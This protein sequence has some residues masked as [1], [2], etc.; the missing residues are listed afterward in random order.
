M[1]SIF[2]K[3]FI[4]NIP[5]YKRRVIRRIRNSLSKLH[6]SIDIWSSPTRTNLQAI[7]CHFL[8][9]KTRKVMKACLALAE[10]PEQY[11]AEEQAD[12]FL[13]VLKEYNIPHNHIGAF[14]S[15]N[16]GSNDKMIR[17]LQKTILDLPPVEHARVRCLGHIINLAAHAFIYKQSAEADEIARHNQLSQGKKKDKEEVQTPSEWRKLGPVGKLFNLVKLIHATNANT[18]SFKVITGCQMPLANTTRWNSWFIMIYKALKLRKGINQWAHSRKA[19]QD[20]SLTH[21]EWRELLNYKNFL[22]PF[23]QATKAAEGDYTSLQSVQLSMDFLADHY[24]KAAETY[25]D[26]V[27]TSARITASHLTFDKYYNITDEQPL[28]AAAILLHPSLRRSYLDKQ[29]A[30]VSARNKIPYADNAVKAVTKLWEKYKPD[31][32]SLAAIKSDKLSDFDQFM[33]NVLNI[34]EGSTSDE[35]ERFIKVIIPNSL[36]K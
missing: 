25:R 4:S 30:R 24:A 11:R 23:W 2:L 31:S 27:S 29:W 7:C 3:A 5:R 18:N 1:Y 17:I 28:Y 26:N 8:D 33:N 36:P 6:F 9:A 13:R 15:D 32:R 10:H 19:A 35:F 22:L 12:A 16:H 14:T 34:E 20:D 21:D